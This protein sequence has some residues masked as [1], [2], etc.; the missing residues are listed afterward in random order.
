MFITSAFAG[1]PA[2]KYRRAKNDE[3]KLLDIDFDGGDPN[4]RSRQASPTFAAG[5]AVYTSAGISGGGFTFDG[6]G[7]FVDIGNSSAYA[8]GVLAA[9]DAVG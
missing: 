3:T 9:V 6:A 4:D 2:H 5:N 1:G 7:D 8:S